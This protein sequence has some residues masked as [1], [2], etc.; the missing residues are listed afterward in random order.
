[1]DGKQDLNLCDLDSVYA[2]S[3]IYIKEMS[4]VAK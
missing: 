1:M 3:N 2:S 4:Q